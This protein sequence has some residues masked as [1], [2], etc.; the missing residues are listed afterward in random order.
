MVAIL[1]RRAFAGHSLRAVK[2]DLAGTA[3]FRGGANREPWGERL[4]AAKEIVKVQ[5]SFDSAA[6]LTSRGLLFRSG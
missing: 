1:I 3:T 6:S 4:A 2:R 5:G